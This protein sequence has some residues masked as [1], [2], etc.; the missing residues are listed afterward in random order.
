MLVFFD[1]YTCILD[2][3]LYTPDLLEW[4]S[5]NIEL[6]ARGLEMRASDQSDRGVFACVRP[7]ANLAKSP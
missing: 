5:G 3:V 1:V 2:H 4:N 7:T 6:L